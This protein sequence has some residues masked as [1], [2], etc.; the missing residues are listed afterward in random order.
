MPRLRRHGARQFQCRPVTAHRL[1]ALGRH[2]EAIEAYREAVRLHPA[3]AEARNNLANALSSVGHLDEAREQ[4][5]I[6]VALRPESLQIRQNLADT[7]QRLGRIEEAIA[8]YREA[9][10]V[11]PGSAE[12]YNNMG[13]A[14][15]RMI[16]FMLLSLGLFALGLVPVVGVV[17]TLLQLWLTARTVAWELMDPYFDCLDIRYA[18]QKQFIARLQKPLLGFGFPVALLFAIPFAGPLC[19]GVAQAA[20]ATFVAR[21]FPVDPRETTAPTPV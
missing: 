14:L 12:I 4:L 2:A 5:A 16:K 8:A 15:R 21:E 20:A 6:A 7:L 3:N 1:A 10:R 9:I 19:F 18:E 13:I 11:N 17:A